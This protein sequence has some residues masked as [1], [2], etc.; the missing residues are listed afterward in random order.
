M[1]GIGFWAP[2]LIA[3]MV[4]GMGKGGMPVVGMLGVPILSLAVSPVTAAGLLLPVYVLSDMF[5]L[6]AY[7]HAFDRRVLAILGVGVTIGVGL[8]WAT[9]KI[10]PEWAV[11]TLVGAI[12]VVFAIRL[13]VQ[14]GDVAPREAKIAPGLFWGTLTGF[15]SFV[16]HSGA[17]PYQVYVR[18][19]GLQKMV[20][21]GTNTILFTYVNAIK[22]IPYWALGQFT[23]TNLKVA[24][25]L[26]PAAAIA[27]FLGVKLVKIVPEKLF[28]RLITWSL[29]AVSVKLIWDGLSR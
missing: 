18:P 28:F 5:G 8:G 12:G 1:D 14:R 26:M 27:V 19:L 9:A 24:F 11:T 4:V 25:T 17:P 10:T 22:L 3:A 21:A 29:L 23:P 15:T 2:A 7:R 20:Y 6:Y 13:L 16:S